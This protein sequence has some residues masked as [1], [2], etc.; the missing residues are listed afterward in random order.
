M[1]APAPDPGG[2]GLVANDASYAKRRELR[3][4]NAA[5]DKARPGARSQ[6]LDLG[7]SNVPGQISLR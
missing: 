3:T 2:D 5:A 1:E 6:D 7:E 4:R